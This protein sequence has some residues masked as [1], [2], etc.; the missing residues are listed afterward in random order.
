MSFGVEGIVL[1]AVPTGREGGESSGQDGGQMFGEIRLGGG[2]HRV[3]NDGEAQVEFSAQGVREAGGF[4]FASHI[5]SA[6]FGTRRAGVLS[7]VSGLGFIV[8]DIVYVYGNNS[9]Y[10]GV[11][12]QLILFVLCITNPAL[13]IFWGQCMA[14]G[15]E[16]VTR[17]NFP[18]GLHRVTIYF[19]KIFPLPLA[20]LS[21]W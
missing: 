20:R 6:E 9:N 15:R 11:L 21:T 16:A 12:C 18:G 13:A 2:G 1:G 3:G 17:R 4:S 7:L 8:V 19:S 14:M 5:W 10:L